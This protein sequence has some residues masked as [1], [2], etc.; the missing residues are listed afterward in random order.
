MS[1]AYDET[2]DRLAELLRKGPL[3]ALQISQRTKCCKPAAYSR[4]AALKKRGEPVV[5]TRRRLLGK[6]G[7]YAIAY[8]IRPE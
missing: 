2:L 7:P 3:T 6:T 1:D 5:E 8:E 4:V